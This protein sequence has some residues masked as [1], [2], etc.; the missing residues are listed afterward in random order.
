MHELYQNQ[1]NKFN[2]A[3]SKVHFHKYNITKKTKNMDD[4]IPLQCLSSPLL[5][6]RCLVHSHLYV[7]L[8]PVSFNLFTRSFLEALEQL[9]YQG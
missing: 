3:K 7:L 4:H 2:Q 1:A 8:S 9:P 6:S 5:T